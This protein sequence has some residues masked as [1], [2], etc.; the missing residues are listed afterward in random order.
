MVPVLVAVFLAQGFEEIEAV[1]VIDVL[2]RAGLT[3]AVVAVG[4]GTVVTGSHGISITADMTENELDMDLL[5]AI[6]LPGGLPGTTN[7]EKSPVIQKA[8]DDAVCKGI[9]ICAICAA[10][11]ILG[12]KDLLKGRNATCFPGYEPE[13]NGANV[14]GNVA[15][16]RPFITGKGAGVAVDFALGIVAELCSLECANQLR[17]IMQCI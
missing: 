10:P 16:D 9:W 6:V 8:I 7:L 11:S 5:E 15:V 12:R 2:R 3:V 1:A 17:S 14:G 13:L 4:G